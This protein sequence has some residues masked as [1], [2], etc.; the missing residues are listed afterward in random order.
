MCK[1]FISELGVYNKNKKPQIEQS[2]WSLIT[3]HG[4]II[5]YL[6]VCIMIDY[7]ILDINEEKYQSVA[8]ILFELLSQFP[9]FFAYDDVSNVNANSCEFSFF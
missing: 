6:H 5:I 7:Y 4:R 2:D 8:K 1:E 3:C 9:S